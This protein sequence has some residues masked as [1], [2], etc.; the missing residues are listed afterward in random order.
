M[1]KDLIKKNILSLLMVSFLSTSC[2]DNGPEIN[3]NQEDIKKST[4]TLSEVLNLIDKN[5]ISKIDENLFIEECLKNALKNIDEHSRYLSPEEYKRTLDETNGE[6]GGIGVDVIKHIKGL[7][8]IN[9]LKN[10]PADAQGIRTGDI[11]T[12]IDGISLIDLSYIEIQ[13]L[14]NGVINSSVR[15]FIERNFTP[16]REFQIKREKITKETIFSFQEDHI[17]YIGITKFSH[18]TTSKLYKILKQFRNDRIKSLIVDLRNN[19]GGSLEKAISCVG[20]FIGQKKIVTLKGQTTEDITEYVAS[21][22]S[23]L[24]NVPIIVLIN[25]NSA[26]AAEIV[27]AA[28]KD[29][30]KGILFGT[31]TFG[32][33]SVQTLFPLSNGGALNLTTALFYSP[34]QNIINQKGIT[35]D[36]LIPEADREDLNNHNI[37]NDTT[38]LKAKEFLNGLLLVQNK[39]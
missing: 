23:V 10:S 35:P 7:E 12:H 28:F 1:K 25:K 9:I 19:P 5:F 3:N 15:V 13:R 31:K 38:Y 6:Y 8:I 22:K 18:T 2:K 4:Q 17:G 11:I 29:H 14:F 37:R 30:K 36:Y 34:S 21:E 27:A 24:K 16:L 20:Y 32:K 33:G 39:R 26:S